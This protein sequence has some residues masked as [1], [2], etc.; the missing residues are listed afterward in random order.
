MDYTVFK[1][2]SRR[3]HI[4]AGE[5][6]G[7]IRF[8][9]IVSVGHVVTLNYFVVPF[10]PE[11]PCPFNRFYVD[12]FYQARKKLLQSKFFIIFRTILIIG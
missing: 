3:E 9:S 6:F 10:P 7:V 2:K 4:E 8:K 1:D 12:G 11:N 5:W